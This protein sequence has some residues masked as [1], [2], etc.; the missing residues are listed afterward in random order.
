MLGLLPE[1]EHSTCQFYHAHFMTDPGMLSHLVLTYL[2]AYTCPCQLT[3]Y[4]MLNGR[5]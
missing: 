4:K 2:K 5:V 1:L 3:Y